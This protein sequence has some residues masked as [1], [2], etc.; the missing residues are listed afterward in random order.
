M[1]KTTGKSKGNHRTVHNRAKL[2]H[3]VLDPDQVC[4]LLTPEKLLQIENRAS[5]PFLP[6]EGKFYCIICDK[7]FINEGA[8]KGHEK[9][10]Q[11]RLRLR[12]VK[13]GGFKPS[14]AYLISGK[15]VDNGKRVTQK[16][17]AQPVATNKQQQ[18]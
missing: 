17:S 5:D 13:D 18:Q 7:H 6:G 4:E 12:E 3:R 14:D 15:G 2:A 1:G 11:H 10:G 9:G 8:F 16:P